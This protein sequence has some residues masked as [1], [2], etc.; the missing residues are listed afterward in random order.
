MRLPVVHQSVPGPDLVRQALSGQV[1]AYR[2][3]EVVDIVHRYATA[4]ADHLAAG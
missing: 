1:D 3:P 4:T 2:I